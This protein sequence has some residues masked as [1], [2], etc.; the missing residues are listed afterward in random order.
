MTLK[1]GESEELVRDDTDHKFF[2]EW[3]AKAGD[4][5]LKLSG[6]VSH[7]FIVLFDPF[8]HVEKGY[9]DFLYVASVNIT[10]IR[11]AVYDTTCILNVGDHPFI[12]QPSYINYRMMDC[13]RFSIIKSR[14]ESGE[15]KLNTPIRHE[16]LVKVID[17][18]F[19]SGDTKIRIIKELQHLKSK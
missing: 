12:T 16:I 7:L 3:D 9:G 15:Y 5:F 4:T 10:S 19:E 14:V 2:M 8:Q 18:I 17:G 11:T 6:A 1:D 13:E